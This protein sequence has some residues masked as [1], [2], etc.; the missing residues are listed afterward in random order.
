MAIY[1]VSTT[2]RSKKNLYKIGKHTG[3][4]RQLISRYTTPLINPIV[5]FFHEVENAHKMEDMI[6]H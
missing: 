6:K 5:F 2:S 3:T 4:K 1:I